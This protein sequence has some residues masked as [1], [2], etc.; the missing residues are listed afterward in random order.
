MDEAWQGTRRRDGLVVV[1]G[2]LGWIV[3]PAGDAAPVDRCPCCERTLP[4]LT[5][6]TRVADAAFPLS[7]LC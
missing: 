1:C 7:E 3:L 5:L 2:F 6:A 4:T